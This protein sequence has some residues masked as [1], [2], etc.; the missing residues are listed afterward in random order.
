[1]IEKG[2]VSFTA[3]VC[4]KS[5]RQKLRHRIGSKAWPQLCLPSHK[6]AANLEMDM[7]MTQIPTLTGSLACRKSEPKTAKRD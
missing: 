4:V 5:K 7:M 6:Q 2:I 3:S 1:M